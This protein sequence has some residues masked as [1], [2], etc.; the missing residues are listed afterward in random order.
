MVLRA[1]PDWRRCGRADLGVD[2]V[3]VGRARERRAVAQDD[4]QLGPL[5]VVDD[6]QRIRGEAL[7]QLVAAQECMRRRERVGAQRQSAQIDVLGLSGSRSLS[8]W[9]IRVARIRTGLGL[10]EHGHEARRRL[11]E[12]VEPLLRADRTPR[13]DAASGEHDWGSLAS[14]LGGPC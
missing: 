1:R 9:P 4:R 8:G 5:E 10:L 7:D 14:T 6:G 11:A 2:R 13:H 3:A 12:R